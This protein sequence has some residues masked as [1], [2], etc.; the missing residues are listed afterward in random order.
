MKEIYRSF[1]G[2]LNAENQEGY[3]IYELDN[4]YQIEFL[5]VWSGKDRYFRIS[6]DFLKQEDFFDFVKLIEFENDIINGR[7]EYD[8]MQVNYNN[9]WYTGNAISKIQASTGDHNWR[10]HVR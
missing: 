2:K 9:K 5:S 6:K 4:M 3:I 8:D 10:R 7:Y 1:E